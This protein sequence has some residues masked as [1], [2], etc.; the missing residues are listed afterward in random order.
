MVEVWYFSDKLKFFFCL[1]LL[2][3][4]SLRDTFSRGLVKG[5]SYTFC[6][7]YPSLCAILCWF[8]T[9]SAS[10]AAATHL[11]G[12]QTLIMLV[13]ARQESLAHHSIISSGVINNCMYLYLKKKGCTVRRLLYINMYVYIHIKNFSAP[14]HYSQAL[15]WVWALLRSDSFRWW[16]RV[17]QTMWEGE[18]S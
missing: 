6:T 9:I 17:E 2:V 13:P 1:F 15:F 16:Q 8:N 5:T 3:L 12:Q 14:P 18:K 10:L 4:W 7:G 11:L